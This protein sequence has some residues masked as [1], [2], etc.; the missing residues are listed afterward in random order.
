L[1]RVPPSFRNGLYAGLLTAVIFGL[2]L[3]AL[4]RP[5][6]QLRLHSEH[7]FA[8]IEKRNWRA[9][10]EFIGDNYQDRWGDDRARLTER[11]REVFRFLPNARIETRAPQVRT[12]N[13]QGYWT[14]QITINGGAGEFASVIQERVNSLSAPFELE[15]RRQSSKPWDWKLVCIRNPSLEIPDL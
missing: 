5:E 1:F 7:L 15:W 10:A 11:M 4:W 9:V 6:R 2:Y 14:S 8:Q 3:A 13:A 12:E